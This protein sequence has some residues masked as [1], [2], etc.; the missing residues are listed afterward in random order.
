MFYNKGIIIN[1][2]YMDMDNNIYNLMLQLTQ[3]Q[4]SVWR[5]NK[6]Y[7]NDSNNSKECKIF[8]QEFKNQKEQNIQKMKELIK[9]HL[10]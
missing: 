6:Y 9:K 4:K 5:I 7:T 10:N 3:E 2:K 1:L 8:W